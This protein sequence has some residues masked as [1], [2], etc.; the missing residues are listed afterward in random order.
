MRKTLTY[1][2]YGLRGGSGDGGGGFLRSATAST[3]EAMRKT[4]TSVIALPVLSTFY[5]NIAYSTSRQD[6]SVM[7]HWYT[8]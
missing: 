2:W 6:C 8:N 5:P 7:L 4:P 1:G 3:L